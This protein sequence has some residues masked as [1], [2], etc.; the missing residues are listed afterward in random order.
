MSVFTILYEES[1]VKVT[2]TNI[3]P[4]LPHIMAK[5]QLAYTWRNYVAVTLCISIDDAC[6]VMDTWIPRHFRCMQCSIGVT[7]DVANR[8]SL[9]IYVIYRKAYAVFVE[10]LTQ[11]LDKYSICLPIYHVYCWLWMV[12]SGW[13]IE[14]TSKGHSRSGGNKTSIDA[15]Y[16]EAIRVVNIAVAYCKY[17]IHYCNAFHIR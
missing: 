10:M 6:P 7:H 1:D 9:N 16:V 11:H 3:S 5:K 8:R 13:S 17:L 14:E 2:I 15:D 4:S 12:C